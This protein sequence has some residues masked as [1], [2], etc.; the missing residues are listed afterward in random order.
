MRQIAI[1]IYPS[2]LA[3]LLLC[4]LILV[5]VDA[6]SALAAPL[7]QD[8]PEANISEVLVDHQFQAIPNVDRIARLQ[9]RTKQRPKH[10]DA[11]QIH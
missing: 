4:A 11:N 2:R 1:R 9:R 6:G 7:R 5:S 8:I 3:A 10:D